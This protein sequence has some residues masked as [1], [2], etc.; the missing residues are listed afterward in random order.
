MENWKQG[1]KSSL[2]LF[3]QNGKGEGTLLQGWQDKRYSALVGRGAESG[4]K[5]WRDGDA[6][7]GGERQ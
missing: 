5:T 3:S 1:S 2:G 6:V 7:R 4:E